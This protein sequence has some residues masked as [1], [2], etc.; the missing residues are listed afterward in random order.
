[1]PETWVATSFGALDVKHL[2]S[3]ADSGA[4]CL[5]L[6]AQPAEPIGL[7]GEAAALWRHLTESA[8]TDSD[9]STRQRI[10][11]RE[12]ENFGLAAR[13][14][15]HRARTTSVPRPW[16]TSALH[17]L[18]YSLVANIA[19]EADVGVV[20]IKGP[21]L[22]RQGLRERAH[23]GDVDVW[24]KRAGISTLRDELIKW[25]WSTAPTLMDG[26]PPSHSVT[27]RPTSWGCEIDLHYDFPGIGISGDEAF[28]VL[29]QL[30]EPLTF[31]GTPARVPAA[32]AHAVISALHAVRPR[33]GQQVPSALTGQATEFLHRVGAGAMSVARQLRADAALSPILAA[34][35][36]GEFTPPKYDVPTNWQWRTQ[37]T[38]FRSYVMM[39]RLIPSTRR[40]RWLFRVIWPSREYAF[41]WAEAANVQSRTAFGVRWRRLLRG[42]RRAHRLWLRQP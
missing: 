31:A 10:L 30:S 16:L 4:E 13:D 7:R 29:R 3:P 26:L 11:V 24:A 34:V 18:I 32:Q 19:S 28:A 14:P 42:M 9:L 39:L 12:F 20:F 22:H 38:R 37:P 41:A 1:M 17:E 36:P 21:T 15:D 35:F 27:M 8:V 33:P 5:I 40:P 25:G 23:S 2:P 6:P